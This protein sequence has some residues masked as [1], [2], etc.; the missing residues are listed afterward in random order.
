MLRT[1][2]KNTDLITLIA[3][4]LLVIIGII[5]IYSAGYN[6]EDLKSDYF[7]QFVWLI[8]SLVALTVVWLIDYNVFGILSIPL[9]L[10]CLGLLVGVLFTEPIYGATSWFQVGPVSI[11]PSEI[12]KIIYILLS[13]KFMDFVLSKDKKAINRWYIILA[14]FGI[15]FLPVILILMQPDFGTAAVFLFITIFML[16][17]AGINYK[18]I[19]GGILLLVVVVPVVYFFV[20]NDVQKDRILVFLDPELDPLGSGYNAIQ[21]KIAVGA[22][23]LFGKGLLHGT[24]TQFGYLPVKSSDFIFSVISEE[25]GFIISVLLVI[26]YTV[27]LVRLVNIS[28]TAKDTYGS[29]VA[30]GVF[31]MLFFHF[32]ENIGMTMGLLPITGIPLPFVSY[33][34]SNLLTNFIALGIVLSISARRQRTFFAI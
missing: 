15:M 31:G 16:F 6:D 9:Y 27:L 21:S 17:K 20:L 30:I 4:I 7:K 2:L 14:V 26:I 32:I 13:A 24:Q 33:G 18:Y 11:Q 8:I 22:G 5:G 28:R 19:L 29:L 3:V 23:K 34:G 12:T 25:M 1:L 10:L